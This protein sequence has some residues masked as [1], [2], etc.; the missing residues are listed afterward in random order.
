MKQEQLVTDSDLDHVIEELGQLRRF[1]GSPAEFWP[2]FLERAARLAQAKLGLLLAQG[3]DGGAWRYLCL[4]PEKSRGVIKAA[5][6]EAKIEE[7]AEASLLNRSAWAKDGKVPDITGNGVVVGV[8][9]GLEEERAGVAVF[10]LDDASGLS[11]E[12]ATTRLKLVADTPGAYQLGRVLDQAKTDVGRFADGLDLMV[13]LNEQKRYLAAAMTFCNEAASRYRC[14]RVSLGWL[15]GN[16]VRLQAISHMERFEKKMDVVQDLEAAMEEAVDQD[17]EILWPRPENSTAVSRHHESFAKGQGSRSMVSLPIRLDDGP[18]GVLTCERSNEP[19]S[20]ATIRGLRLLCDLV[21]RRLGDLKEHDRWFGARMAAAMRRGLGRLLGVEH[22]FAKFAGLVV[23]GALAFLVF[24]KMPYRVEAP[25]ILKTD[26]LVYLPAPFEGYIDEVR[27][28][29]GD[30]VKEGDV[31]LRFDTRELLL[32]EATAIAN[33][34]RFTREA[35]KARAQRAAAEMK[36]AEAL[37]DQAKARLDLV[38]YH[39]SHAG[40]R[41]PFTGVVV[42]GDLKELHGTPVK[43]GDVLFKLARIEK[44]YV[45]L[46]VDERDV[47][48]VA[49]DGTGEIS[50]MSRPDLEF[51]VRVERVDPVAVARDER[52][53][54]LIRGAISGD[55]APWWRPGMSGVAKVNVGDR[56]LLWILTHRTVDFLRLY[57]WW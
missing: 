2:A 33:Q 55:A 17:E 5:R 51:P 53:V 26:D 40:V 23:C 39:L 14:D 47:H 25:F 8:R 43:K 18:A 38:R 46:E 22:T 27:V 13:L 4:W 30:L 11:T 10:L 6:L 28:E 29:V 49:A 7:V 15:E 52:N 45:E 24:G 35:E 34:N 21:A 42:E 3:E 36:I 41:A 9:L 48:E 12:E 1:S 37:A 56:N 20:E 16:Y 57:F 44:M 19:F 32:E 54:F 31:L 50:F